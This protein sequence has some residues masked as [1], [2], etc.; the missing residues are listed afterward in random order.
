MGYQLFCKK[1]CAEELAIVWCL[2]F[3]WLLDTHTVPA[4]WKKSYITPIPKKPGARENNDLRPV[5]LT[6]NVMKCF[7]KC[8]ISLLEKEVEPL[9]DTSQFAYK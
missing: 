1:N 5:D 2:L 6:S 9:L 4:L 8:V 7:D 3:Q